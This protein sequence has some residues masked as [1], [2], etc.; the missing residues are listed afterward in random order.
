MIANDLSKDALLARL[1]VGFPPRCLVHA[2]ETAENWERYGG[3]EKMRDL[4]LKRLFDA[5]RF[6]WNFYVK[7]FVLDSAIDR[8]HLLGFLIERGML[9]RKN[10]EGTVIDV[11]C[12]LGASVDALAL[13]GGKV[14]GTDCGKF[15]CESP[16]GISI[17]D[18]EGRRMVRSRFPE[19]AEL[20]LVSCFNVDWVEEMP[21]EGFAVE[22]YQ[23]ALKALEQGGQ[24]LYTFSERD[25]SMHKKLAPLPHS[26]II[27]LPNGLDKREKYV[28]V[29]T[30]PS[31]RTGN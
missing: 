30:K 6:E 1:D 25:K 3:F 4:L 8:Y 10:L 5:W 23:E 17:L 19:N 11:G 16:S 29:A 18:L 12:H 31:K 21:N 26:S 22:L 20:S 7:S 14:I 9:D 24:V 28:F 2:K 15:A 13:Y 27:E